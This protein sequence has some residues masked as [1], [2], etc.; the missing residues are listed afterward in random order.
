MLVTLKKLCE[1][2]CKKFDFIYHFCIFQHL[3]EEGL[4]SVKS[5]IVNRKIRDF[6]ES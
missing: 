3:G 6:D 2:M 1:M 5:E 4:A